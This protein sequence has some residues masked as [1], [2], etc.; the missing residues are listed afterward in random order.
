MMQVTPVLGPRTTQEPRTRMI[1]GA[2]S[3]TFVVAGLLLMAA[4]EG[5][6][7]GI[8]VTA[9]GTVA[10]LIALTSRELRVALPWA[11]WRVDRKDL[12]A[13]AVFYAIVVGLFSLAFRGFTTDNTLGMFLSFGGALLL[14]VAG[15]VIY[16]VWLR[17]RSLSSL[18]I[19]LKG[20]RGV[21]AP[22]LLF[23]GVQFA[24][25]L[26]G[27]DLPRPVDWVPLLAM[28]LTVGLFESIFFRGFVQG[29]LEASFGTAPAVAGAAILYA[30]YHVG[31]GM[32][33]E[34]MVFLF[35]LGIVY[36]VAFRVANNILVL[37]PLLTPL[38]SFFA[39]L[40]SGDLTGELPW[41]AI[42]GFADV[43]AL[44]AA[45]I[46]LARRHQRKLD[47]P[48][49]ETPPAHWFE[50]QVAGLED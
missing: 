32:G 21:V 6:A 34:E 19:T 42:L 31:Y 20:W 11:R 29:R 47:R 25:T 40:E 44:M 41:A 8:A 17:R 4:L 2:A 39:Q 28:S 36:A 30:L 26:W 49:D 16:T 22:A 33:A 48:S 37:W 7:F 3:A 18:G 35:G 43:L 45:V 24:I 15:P 14:G 23:A 50:E 12:L 46:W 1:L 10:L 5:V 13:I 27:Y 9:I 38:G